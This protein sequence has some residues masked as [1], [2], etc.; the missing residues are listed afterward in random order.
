[1]NTFQDYKDLATKQNAIVDALSDKLNS[2]PTGPFGLIPDEVRAT[3]EFISVKN[4]FNREFKRL[5][6]INGQGVK[7]YNKELQQER[8]E[9]MSKLQK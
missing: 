7:K 3:D 2:Y 1:M 8:R 6:E 5:R 9:K 4:Q